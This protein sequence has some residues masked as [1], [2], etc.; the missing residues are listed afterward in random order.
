M[1]SSFSFF[2]APPSFPPSQVLRPLSPRL[3]DL[4]SRADD[5]APNDEPPGSR[6]LEELPP[7]KAEV[8]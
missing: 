1:S 8:T 7:V 3:L 4:G 5:A 6:R 2:P